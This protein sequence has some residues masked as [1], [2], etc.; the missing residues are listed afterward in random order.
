MLNFIE[1]HDIT[2][3][4]LRFYYQAHWEHKSPQ[5]SQFRSLFY[6]IQ[7]LLQSSNNK[8]LNYICLWFL[9]NKSLTYFIV[10]IYGTHP[11]NLNSMFEQEF[12]AVETGEIKGTW[13]SILSRF[14]GVVTRREI[15]CQFQKT[16][17][18]LFL[19]YNIYDRDLIKRLWTWSPKK[20]SQSR[21]HL[22]SYN[23]NV[24]LYCLPWCTIRLV[25]LCYK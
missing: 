16:F 24:T 4:T 1:L 12:N 7:K 18:F 13:P 20:T 23:L 10:H 25:C 2:K 22:C 17:T 14:N 19:S 5:F 9:Q 3:I 15:L 21:N 11:V 8:N 6:W